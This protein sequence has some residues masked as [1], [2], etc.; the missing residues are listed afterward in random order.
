VLYTYHE[1]ILIFFLLFSFELSGMCVHFLTFRYW[2]LADLGQAYTISHD[3]VI[4]KY[5]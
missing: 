5:G 4:T 1:K 2:D 3:I